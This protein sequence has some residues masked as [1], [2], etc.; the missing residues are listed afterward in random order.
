MMGPH[1]WCKKAPLDANDVKKS[2]IRLIVSILLAYNV[3]SDD[4]LQPSSISLFFDNGKNTNSD[5][6]QD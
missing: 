6:K 3:I 4:D 2:P 5:K 1:Q